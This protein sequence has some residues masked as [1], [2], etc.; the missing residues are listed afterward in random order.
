[1][2]LKAFCSRP[3]LHNNCLQHRNFEP[4]KAVV[5]LERRAHCTLPVITSRIVDKRGK[6]R[7]SNNKLQIVAG[8]PL[9]SSIP[10]VGPIVNFVVN[11][12]VFT[13]I[14]VFGAIRFILG[15]SRTT[16]SDTVINRFGLTAMWPGKLLQARQEYISIMC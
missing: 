7:P 15:F 4:L 6:S 3:I 16:Y 10:I 11:P 1:M 8:L 5:G 2:S 12:T 9:V 14:Y 13:V